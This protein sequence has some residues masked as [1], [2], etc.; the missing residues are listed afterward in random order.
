MSFP[1]FF[2]IEGYKNLNL[3]IIRK[4][5]RQLYVEGLYSDPTKN[6]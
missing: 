5:T 4:S 3:C 6:R 1:G 2:S